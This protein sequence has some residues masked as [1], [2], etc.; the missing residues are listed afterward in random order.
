MNIKQKVTLAMM[1]MA[2]IP[3]LISSLLL[4]STAT[5]V[6]NEALEQAAQNQLI[7]IRD[8]KK[9]QIEEYFDTI[10]KQ[11]LTFSNSE[12]I[13]SAMEEFALAF[14]QIPTAS[15]DQMR[16]EL[17]PYYQ[18]QFEAE[19]RNQNSGQSFDSQRLLNQLTPKALHW[20]L[21]YIQNNPKP[22][23][24]KHELDA[25]TDGSLYSELHKKHHPHIRDY[26]EKFEY[27]DIFLV[28]PERGE[29]VY[30][31]F[32]ELDFATSLKSGPYANSGIAEAFRQALAKGSKESVALIDFKPYL[33][34]Y[35]GQASFIA[36]PIM[37]DAGQLIGILIFQM[38]VG[39][40]NQIMT[41]Q[42]NWKARG[43]G[44]SGETY[45]VGSDYK[46]RSLSRFLIE[47]LESYLDV[48]AQAGASP[49]VL[50]QMKSKGSNLGLQEIRTQGTQA[51]ISGQTGFAIFPDYRNVPVLSA[52]TPLSIEGLDWVLMSEIDKAEAFASEY[53][54]QKEIALDAAI[55]ILVLTTLAIGFGVWIARSL[56][57][58]ITSLSQIM[59]SV[60]QTNDLALRA[61][62]SAK[63]E[64]GHMANSFNSMLQKF[65][66]VIGRVS[67]STHLVATASHQLTIAA[68][69]NA[70]NIESQKAETDQIAAAMNEMAST[71]QEVARNT[72]EASE[73]ANTSSEKV[74]TGQEIV[75]QTT[76]AIAR[77]SE[78]IQ[79]A[80]QVI[81]DLANESKNIGS[82]TD[83]IMNIAEQTNL[84][85]LNAAI[86][87][88]R[89]GD[90]GRGFAVVA[91]E[92]RTLAQRTQ[93]SI[94]EIE[95]T[96]KRLLSGTQQA[97]TAMQASQNRATQGVELAGQ[98]GGALKVIVEATTQISDLNVQI[99]SAAEQQSLTAE[100]MS[101]NVSAIQNVAE[102]TSASSEESATASSELS[103]EAQQLQTLVSQFRIS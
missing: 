78:N 45:L 38:P 36:S 41:S 50:A 21:Q 26:L 46:A 17:A 44:E 25:A 70:Q 4:G 55:I 101:R 54:L 94:Y 10:R 69:E 14:E 18:G 53:A 98:A 42:G 60:E 75:G 102:Q 89:A 87:A 71:V 1:A 47:D 65:E 6:A 33:P 58:P 95:E 66:G 22:L 67:N 99:A 76:E 11:V 79:Q 9:A 59:E 23:G 52:Y 40:L 82:I 93:E 91:D 48:M 30:S 97:V 7:A 68:G 57:T 96:V 8:A 19:F 88:A 31:V 80:D 83:V 74:L 90:Q 51:A 35:E 72:Q 77:L 5:L 3:L 20:Q 32:K 34:S 13:I 28:E 103:S 92:V 37:T 12:M 62:I 63:D 27:Y 61:Q 43:L 29:I 64:I 39:H 86:E 2:A 85:A 16:R 84:L 24:S 73:A 56:T 100:E 49:Q 81:R 15:P